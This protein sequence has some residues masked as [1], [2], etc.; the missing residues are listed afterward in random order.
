M[1]L[2]RLRQK[3]INARPKFISLLAT[4]LISG[5]LVSI[6]APANAAECVTTS[7]SATNGDTI[8]TFANVG[9]CDWTVPAGV[10]NAKVLVVGGGGSASA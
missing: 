3:K 2:F 7:T 10:F 8:L 6:P 4:T 9:S 1:I 5:L